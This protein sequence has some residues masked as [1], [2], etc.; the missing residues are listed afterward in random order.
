MDDKGA[1]G[2]KESRL[3]KPK[4]VLF[5]AERIQLGWR[6]RQLSVGSGLINTGVICY[7][8]ATL[9]VCSKIRFNCA[10]HTA[11]V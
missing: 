7:I 6:D 5:P 8:N 2:D 11:L 1:N 3:Q 4:V 9:Q 10:C